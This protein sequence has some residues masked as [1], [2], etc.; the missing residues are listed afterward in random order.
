MSL[1]LV[2]VLFSKMLINEKRFCKM[3]IVAHISRGVNILRMYC[4]FK[5]RFAG[6][7]ISL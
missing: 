2:D 1:K 6:Y 5:K 7:V 4:I 3:I